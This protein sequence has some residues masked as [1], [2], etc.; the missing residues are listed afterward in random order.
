MSDASSSERPPQLG[1]IICIVAA[2][3][4]L[5]GGVIGLRLAFRPFTIPSDAMAPTL[6]QGS[7]IFSKST[8][9]VARGDVVFFLLPR[10]HRT[11]YIKRLIGMP[12]DKIQFH[13]GVLSING[14]DVPRKVLGKAQDATPDGAVEVTRVE[15]KLP[16]GARYVTYDRAPDRD[17][18]TTDVFVIPPGHYF[19]VGDNRDNSLDSRW[20]AEYGVGFVPAANIL[21]KMI[22]PTDGRTP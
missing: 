20:S 9:Q 7:Y 4:A 12:G 8:R 22:W 21:G 1:L 2:A 15:E 5:V 13:E 18:D 19:M 11:V 3:A 10:D 14:V 16:G 6:L 17:G